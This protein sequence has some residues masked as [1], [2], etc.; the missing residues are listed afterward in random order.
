MSCI[1][2][3]SN[4]KMAGP[5]CATEN[6]RRAEQESATR[7]H[8]LRQTRKYLYKLTRERSR[9]SPLR[10]L[11]R[12]FPRICVIGFSSLA[13]RTKRA[14]RKQNKTITIFCFFVYRN[15]KHSTTRRI[16]WVA[17]V[18][19]TRFMG[20]LFIRLA[21]RFSNGNRMCTMPPIR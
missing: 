13:A 7:S 14:E 18:F 15:A 4:V 3:H 11:V 5:L 10:S 21:K 9:L 17:G 16:Y 1:L 12:S 20:K 2:A 6:G 8:T 19:H